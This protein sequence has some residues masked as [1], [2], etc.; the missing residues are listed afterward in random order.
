MKKTDKKIERQIVDA[1]TDVCEL[2]LDDVIG[3]RWL[4]HSV[5]Y[6]MVN[7]SL[8][9]TCVFENDELL[10]QSLAVGSC[11]RLVLLIRTHLKQVDIAL[12]ADEQIVFD[13]EQAC[14]REHAGNWKKRLS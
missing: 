6:K 13:T 11:E 12:D 5:N 3:F 7:R 1:L 14:Q 8:K 4:T 2:A 9:I 10:T